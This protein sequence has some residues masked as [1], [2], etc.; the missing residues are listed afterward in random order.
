MYKSIHNGLLHLNNF[1]S[2]LKIYPNN[3]FYTDNKQKN[4]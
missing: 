1:P 2:L 3:I 4:I